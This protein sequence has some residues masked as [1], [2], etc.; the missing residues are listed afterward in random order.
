MQNSGGNATGAIAGARKI[1]A[2]A[3]TAILANH[4]NDPVIQPANPALPN[5]KQTASSRSS[6]PPLKVVMPEEP[7]R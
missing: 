1:N 2:G 4:H 6:Q 7:E 3:T 5:A